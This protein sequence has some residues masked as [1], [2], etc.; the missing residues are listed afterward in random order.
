MYPVSDYL[1]YLLVVSVMTGG[2]SVYY[3][4]SFILRIKKLKLISSSRKLVGVLFFSLMT[5]ALS[6][7]L[8]GVQGY[9]ALTYETHIASVVVIPKGKQI[10]IAR[11]D[12]PDGSSKRFELAGDEVMVEASILKWK[13]WSNIIGL[14]T[15]YRL[16]RIRGR[17]QEISDEQSNMPTL[18]LI[19]KDDDMDI[20]DWRKQYDYLS[21]LLDVEHGSAS[22]VSAKEK[23]VFELV[24]TTSGLLLRLEE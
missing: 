19:Q 21:V 6:F 10:F 9:Q 18:Y 22:Y 8:I 15:A 12:F 2:I 7:F 1:N 23:R 14:K 24:V 4:F 3:L 11:M 17:Y 13:P 16:D 5:A 20:A